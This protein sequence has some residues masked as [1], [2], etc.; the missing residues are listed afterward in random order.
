MGEQ[1]LDA[2]KEELM[3]LSTSLREERWYSEELHNEV[4]RLKEAFKKKKSEGDADTEDEFVHKVSSINH[5]PI[6]L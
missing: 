6:N 3:E 2:L 1:S 5:S 4:E